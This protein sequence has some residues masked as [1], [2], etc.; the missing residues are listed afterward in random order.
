MQLT[1]QND[2]LAF[3]RFV[4]A[5]AVI[6]LIGFQSCADQPSVQPPLVAADTTGIS[7]SGAI[8]L[9]G[10]VVVIPPPALIAHMIRSKSIPFESSC[11]IDATHPEQW[12][13]EQK[14]ALNLGVLGADLSY[15]I[16]HG[17]SAVI[18][19]YLAS[20]RR[21]TDDLGISH[22]V[23]PELLN[24]IE[25]G[26]DNPEYMLGLHSVFFRNLE[27]YLES[28]KRSSIST[29]ILLGGWIESMHQL[30]APADSIAAH[31][32]DDLLAEQSYT[33]QGIRALALS[34]SDDSFSEIQSSIITLCDA[35]DK[36]EKLYAF[37]E[38]V[39]DQRQSI[40][41]LRSESSVICSDEQL[42]ELHQ[43]INQAR[44]LIIEP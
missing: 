25:A 27:Q 31:P 13:G 24:Q 20:I 42:V 8:L 22:Q 34:V 41:Y 17:Q 18:P 14:K 32:L 44:Q 19:Q 35:L 15:L 2:S 36:L 29:C 12:T 5:I 16:N 30:A 11:T 3:C 37:R 10:N 38:P 40:S 9:Q 43:L 1:N 39:H 26:L 23:N 33:A 28:N 21:L 4:L 7:S 6:I